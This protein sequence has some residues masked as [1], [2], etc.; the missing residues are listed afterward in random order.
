M[1]TTPFQADELAA[2]DDGASALVLD[3]GE[4]DAGRTGS[5][6]NPSSGAA[7][8]G[9]GSGPGGTAE[10]ALAAVPNPKPEPNAKELK[11]IAYEVACAIVVPGTVGS[12]AVSYGPFLRGNGAGGTG[13]PVSS[14]AS[15][16]FPRY[17]D[18]R[19]PDGVEGHQ[20]IPPECLSP[21]ERSALSE[22][23]LGQAGEGRETGKLRDFS[24]SAGDSVGDVGSVD[25]GD[26]GDGWAK[27]FVPNYDGNKVYVFSMEPAASLV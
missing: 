14:P 18:R 11:P 6:I 1:E 20:V 5:A 26:G 22:G 23:R 3:E 27:L 17:T 16:W 24:A 10:P 7:G 2:S 13:T 25:G 8:A 15:T 4:A 19:R 21:G 12:L 9:A